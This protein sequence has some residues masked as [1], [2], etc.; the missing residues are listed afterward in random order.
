MAQMMLTN[1]VLSLY[2]LVMGAKME[3]S[4]I[5]RV[6]GPSL[7]L[8]ASFAILYEDRPRRRRSRRLVIAMSIG[9]FLPLSP[10]TTN[11]SLDV[12][13]LFGFRARPTEFIE[14]KNCP[15]DCI[16]SLAA[17]AASARCGVVVEILSA[18]FLI[19][20]VVVW[21]SSRISDS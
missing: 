17:S 7:C 4:Q 8:S 2:E 10:M 15:K 21:R 18:A 3:R 16:P 20:A 5:L 9:S 13:Q 11:R 19:R 14:E 1:A 6:L 12:L